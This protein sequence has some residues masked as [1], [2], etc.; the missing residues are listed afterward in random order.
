M[1]L[2]GLELAVVLLSL[3][4]QCW[5]HKC[6]VPCWLYLFSYWRH[7]RHLLLVAEHWRFSVGVTQ[8][9]SVWQILATSGYLNSSN[10]SFSGGGD[11]AQMAAI[12][13]PWAWRLPLVT[14]YPHPGGGGSSII[15][16]ASWRPHGTLSHKRNKT[17]Q[18]FLTPGSQ[19]C[20]AAVTLPQLWTTAIIR[21][22][23]AT[24][25]VL[26]VYS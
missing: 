25:D 21:T 3:L 9:P 24:V 14:I 18:E 10:N 13:K 4:L 11:M 8:L 19:P 17:K 6:T 22:V 1:S 20:A 15:Y 7:I 26:T 5:D 2:A 16:L 12:L 23:C